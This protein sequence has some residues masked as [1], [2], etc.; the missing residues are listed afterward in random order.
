MA[1]L[2]IGVFLSPLPE[3]EGV[4]TSERKTARLIPGAVYDTPPE[5]E[6]IV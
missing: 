5:R 2:H 6:T 4:L 1:F 3:G